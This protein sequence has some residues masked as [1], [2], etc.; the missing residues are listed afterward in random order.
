MQT[1]VFHPH[2]FVDLITNSSSTVYITTFTDTRKNLKNFISAVL[3]VAE[4]PYTFDE[5]FAI[6]DIEKDGYEVHGEV[7]VLKTKMKNKEID[8]VLE[9]MNDLYTY[10]AKL[11]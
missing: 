2:S 1:L 3:K 5:L 6:Q 10:E 9:L 8:K 11:Q 7:V 4:S